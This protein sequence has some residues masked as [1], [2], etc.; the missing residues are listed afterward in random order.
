MK[1]LLFIFSVLLIASCGTVRK[2]QS[3]PVELTVGNFNLRGDIDKGDN[4]WK[5]RRPRA[6][7]RIRAAGYDVFGTEECYGYMLED[8]RVDVPEYEFYGQC[9]GDKTGT[10]SAFFY[11]K[12]RFDLVESG[13]FWFSPT[14]ER[15]SNGWGLNYLRICSWGKLREKASGREFYFFNT[16]LD[17]RGKKSAEDAQKLRTKCAQLLVAR[18]REIAGDVPAILTGDLNGAPD[19]DAI[20]TLT[21]LLQ[22]SY[23]AS[24]TPPEGTVGTFHG[25][26]PSPANASR[27]DYILASPAFKVGS[28][29]CCNTDMTE[30]HCASDHYNIIAKLTLE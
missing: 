10:Y 5:M 19:S 12:D 14:P 11:R 15:I 7:A 8:V 9:T 25:Y 27:I 24:A 1:K 28:Y 30:G 22:D 23:V 29:T 3:V 18:I 21:E 26:K 4:S 17:N 6:I 2:V 20:R 13:D 16:H